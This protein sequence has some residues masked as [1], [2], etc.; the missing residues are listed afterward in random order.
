M[1]F[2]RFNKSYPAG[3]YRFINR[4]YL[5]ITYK[6][7]P[8]KLKKF[9]PEPLQPAGDKIHFEF[10][11]MPDSSG[12]GNYTEA[13]QVIPVIHEGVEA[14]FTLAMY[15]DD[16]SPIAAGREI[17]GF[18]KKYAKPT[19][20]VDC[21]TLLGTLDYGKVRVATATMHYKYNELDKN[22]ILKSAQKPN[23]LLKTLP[24]VDGKPK[25]CQLVR[26][27]LKDIDIL[28][29]WGGP[30]TLELHPHVQAPVSEFE[31]KEIISAVHYTSNLTLD[32]GEVAID[33]LANNTL[34][35]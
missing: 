10:I 24:D 7:D 25:I 11:R 29:A 33:Y 23:Y 12:F 32:Y 3:P 17:W 9:L 30:A 1:P 13:G 31:V 14:N 20:E 22:A 21:D 34:K 26:Y 28:G 2:D 27:Y 18:P 8:D 16:F 5:I 19:L 35:K 4:E 6:T 15:L